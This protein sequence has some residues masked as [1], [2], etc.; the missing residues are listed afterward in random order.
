MNISKNTVK[1]TKESERRMSVLPSS[2]LPSHE[3]NQQSETCIIVVVE[4]T[5]VVMAS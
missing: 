1:V 2:S 4:R 5:H 3:E